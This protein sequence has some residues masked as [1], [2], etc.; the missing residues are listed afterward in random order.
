MNYIHEGEFPK[1]QM[2]WR[3]MRTS[4]FLDL[5][6]TRQIY[7]ASAWQFDDPFEGAVAVQ[8]HA[9]PVDPRYPEMDSTERAFAELKR[10][11][12]ISCWHVEDY[13]SD[14]MWRLYSDQ[15]KGVAIVSTPER[16]GAAL[17]PYRTESGN[18]VE[19]L[20]GGNVTYVDLV[21]ERLRV[22][23]L[24]RFY[25]KHRAFSW[26]KEFRCA[27]SLRGAEEWGVPV[28]KEGI[29]VDASLDELIAE[30]H[31][32]PSLEPAERESITQA[33]AKHGLGDRVHVSSLLGRPRYI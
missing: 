9:V 21:Q 24:E 1:D 22:G 28:A 5:L 20:C 26:E 10:L 14:A 12:K 17:T 8:T 13:E 25:F 29:L 16:I 2:V 15:R 33:C 3:Y 27:I 6:Q 30:V 23:M 32:G 31:I 7:F 19:G 18:G 11:T 4:R